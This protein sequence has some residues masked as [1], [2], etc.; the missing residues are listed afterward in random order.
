MKTNLK[1]THS[2]PLTGILEKGGQSLDLCFSKATAILD[3]EGT[4]SGW[5]R[6][7]VSKVDAV[8]GNIRLYPKSVYAQALQKL[9]KMG[10]PNPGEHPHPSPYKGVDGR[11]RYKT[12]IP[13]AAVRFRTAYI[14]EAGNVWA[15]FKTLATEMGRQVQ[16]FIDNGLPIGFSNRMIGSTKKVQR[17][18]G[19]IVEV[20]KSLE[21]LSWDVV[22]NPAEGVALSLPEPLLDE[23]ATLL[24]KEEEEKEMDFFS[25]EV[26]ELEAWLL[27]NGE[28]EE[29]ELC[30]NV[31]KLKQN[32]KGGEQKPNQEKQNI[33]KEEMNEYEN[34]IQKSLS[35]QL[36]KLNYD[37]KTKKAILAGGRGLKSMEEVSSYLN[38]QKAMIDGA[39]AS[40]G[41]KALG[42]NPMTA[43][44]RASIIS[45]DEKNPILPLVDGLMD[46]MDRELIKKDPNFKV[47]KKLRAANR[48]IL[49]STMRHMERSRNG[50]YMEFRRALSNSYSALTDDS[51]PAVGTSGE[52][53]Q[54]AALSLAILQQAWQDVKFLQLC[55]TESFSG[56]TCKMPVEFQNHDIFGEDEFTVGELEGIPTESIQTF[57]LEFGSQWLKRGFVVTKEAE[58][59]LRT[60]PLKYD[61]IARNAASIASRFQRMLDRGI[62]TEMLSRSDEY[63]AKRVLAETAST[64]DLEAVT[65]GLNAPE[66]TN[67]KFRWKL[68]CG[69]TSPISPTAPA[70][71]LVRP[72]VSVW[73]N[74]TGR[75]EQSLINEIIVKDGS[76]NVLTPGRLIASS[77]KIVNTGTQSAQYAVDFENAVIYFVDG[78]VSTSN[79]P[80]ADYS[81]ATNIAF[82]NLAVPTAMADFPARYY[83]RLLEMVDVQKAY[84]GSAP[85]FV[86]PDFLMGSLNAMVP[87][88]QAEL[89]YQRA[90]PEG[91]SLLGGELYF[92]RRNGI[93][94][95]EHNDPWAAG[96][97]RILLGKKNAVR[98]GMGS[99]YE[100]EGPFPHMEAGTGKYTSAKEYF[101]TQQIAINTPLVIDENSV[102]YHPP[103]RTIKYFTQ[104]H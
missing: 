64:S 25:M 50:E 65:P 20:A 76:G 85:R 42:V 56:A 15:E 33:E 5:Y 36:S 68:L 45:V 27:E 47:D 101:A 89:F 8:N 77:G 24:K 51:Q 11:L 12:S 94:L 14:D 98:V 87:F 23:A 46:E 66:G 1:E 81:Y 67:A 34:K 53:A 60:G 73:L 30:K 102:Q 29:A 80:V 19:E 97:G 3:A 38:A 52:F 10:F 40:A 61:A 22:L 82:F 69:S 93:E 70:V 21:L 58:K 2:E 18:C 91:T 79:L 32:Q 35:E 54:S 17:E 13:N 26:K 100:L 96:D 78:V 9:Q 4:K 31:L 43:A 83:N 104:A 37:Q 63:Q 95:C 16:E 86:T 6:Q 99:P 62:S 49:D 103:F 71:P 48:A 7:I 90:L 39:V 57:L 74:Q 72:R 59:E 92:G 88:R 55:M 84:M 44:T 41:L 75:K 28:S